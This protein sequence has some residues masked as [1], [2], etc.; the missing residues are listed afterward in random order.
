MPSIEDS[1]LAYLLQRYIDKASTQEEEEE[2]LALIHKATYDQQLKGLMDKVWSHLPGSYHLSDNQSN[3]ILSEI[4]QQFPLITSRKGIIKKRIIRWSAAAAVLIVLIAAGWVVYKN[5]LHEKL[6]NSPSILAQKP[7]DI[8]PGGNKAVLILGNGSQLVLDSS[9]QGVL[10]RIGNTRVIKTGVGKLVFQQKIGGGQ[11]NFSPERLPSDDNLLI[12]PRGGE[13]MIIL[14]DGTKAWLNAASSLRFPTAFTG[15]ERKVE[16][17]GEAYFEVAK[18]KDKP[19]IVKSG[20]VEVQVLGTHFDVDAYSDNQNDKV[21]LLSGA[22]RIVQTNDNHARL[23][24]PGEAA[25]VNRQGEIQLI[26]HADIAEAIAWKNGLFLFHNTDIH[27]VLKQI[28]R[29]YDVQI[30]YA[31][32]INAQLNGMISRSTTLSQVLNMLEYT[33]KVKFT[34]E[35]RKVTVSNAE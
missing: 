3:R 35:G 33:S 6:N 25:Q 31:E 20:D 18:N 22:V 2:L 28:S 15:S 16:L 1:R 17:K 14:P 23:L 26:K 29:W 32:N 4:Q 13:Y 24:Q 5:N 11:N 34:I 19:F 9:G 12:T 21:T 8:S 27:E 30:D 7:Q 10:A